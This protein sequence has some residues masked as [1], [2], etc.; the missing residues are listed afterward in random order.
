MTDSYLDYLGNS[1]DADK[2]EFDYGQAKADT[3]KNKSTCNIFIAGATGV[4]KSALINALFGEKVVKSGVGK[5]ITQHLE[6]MKIPEKGLILWDTKGIESQDYEGTIQ[7]LKTELKETFENHKSSTN[8]MPHVAWLCINASGTRFEE[9]ELELIS[10]LKEYD[11]PTIIVFTQDQKGRSDQLINLA[12]Q[13][14]NN[15]YKNFSDDRFVRVNSEEVK[16]DENYSIP[17]FGLDKLLEVTTNYIGQGYENAANALLK[18]QRVNNTI[19][20]E[21]MIS[22][23]NTKVHRASAVAGAVG[24]SPIPGSDA[25]IIAAI[26]SKLIYEIN[27]EFELNLETAA[28]TTLITG[29]LG[30]TAIA[31]VGKSVVTGALKLIPG[32]GTVIGGVIAAGTATAITEAIGHA[33]IYALKQYFDENKGKVILP[34]SIDMLLPIIKEYFTTNKK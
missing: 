7:E 23:S 13:E 31:Q 24:A 4:G 20:L 17:V 22:A 6:K 28:A 32:A 33:Y 18:A 12:K 1:Y 10:I 16:F 19:R 21:A 29:V 14:I 26:Q 34:E 8:E 11:I 27:S 9:R 2:N 15:K 5:P 30:I 25:P 3:I